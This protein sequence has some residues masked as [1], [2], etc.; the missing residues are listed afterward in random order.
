[1][2]LFKLFIA[3]LFITFTTQGVAQSSNIKTITFKVD[4]VCGMCKDRIES[5][6]DIKGVKFV[7]WNVN[8]HVCEVIFRTDKITEK[9]IHQALAD[10]GHDTE[11]I[12]ASEKAY[13]QIHGCCKYRSEET[14]K[15]HEK[16]LDDHKHE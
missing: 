6:L 8:S 7:E 5:T 3:V 14:Q 1:M 12:K 11:K 16:E 10:V 9:E 15:A 2:K 13:A 4:G